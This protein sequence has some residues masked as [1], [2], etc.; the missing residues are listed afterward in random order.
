MTEREPSVTLLMVLRIG[1]ALEIRGEN[2]Q[3]LK[4]NLPYDPDI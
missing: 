2:I 3:K 1:P 4:I